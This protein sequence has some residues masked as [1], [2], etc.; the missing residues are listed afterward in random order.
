MS[1][2]FR[3]KIIIYNQIT[4]ENQITESHKLLKNDQFQIKLKKMMKKKV[5]RVQFRFIV[6]VIK[7]AKTIQI[8]LKIF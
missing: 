5:L 3:I 6:V 2:K 8:L 7:G 4:T 1:L